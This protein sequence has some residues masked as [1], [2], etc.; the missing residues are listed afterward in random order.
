MRDLISGLARLMT[1]RLGQRERGAIGVLVAA[2]IGG[3]VLL[4]M[5]ALTIDVGQLYQNRAELQN[6]ADAG[7]LA[8]ARACAQDS[9]NCTP[10]NALGIAG[11]YADA[12]ASQLTGG[13]DGAATPCG[14]GGTLSACTGATGALTQCPADPANVNYVDVNTS[15][16]LP[17]GSTLLP[18]VFAGA[19][20]I[21]GQ[22]VRACAQAEWGTAMTSDSLAVT[23]SFCAWQALTHDTDGDGDD[24]ADNDDDDTQYD[25][26]IPLWLK[27]KG[28]SCTDNAS[29]QKL[30]GGF[31]WLAPSCTSTG[32]STCAN[33]C[34]AVI[35][36][37]TATT[38][39]TGTTYTD[40]GANVTNDC[41]TALQSDLGTTVYIPV[42]DQS[43][44]Q[45]GN[46]YYH[47]I[48]L[49]AFFI[50]GYANMTG[51]KNAGIP[52]PVIPPADPAGYNLC[53]SS[54]DKSVNNQ[55][56]LEGYFAKGLTNL[57]GP[58]SSGPGFGADTIQLTG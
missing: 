53:V 44:S 45:G 40:P 4:G 10:V 28:T 17:D 37:N 9:A 14:S 21:G 19:L 52:Q 29:G 58:I 6:G 57:P 33:P 30:P 31:G 51:L 12:N 23:V 38:P 56:C 55:E 32:N 3:G 24:S 1:Q 50:T 49:A 54:P 18:P 39:P 43:Y 7:A 15:T 41:K 22:T 2:L 8:V 25:H 16:R 27:G 26:L 35:D 13:T 36:I 48:G 42:F 34:T 47:V 5:A 11:N 46:A 20:G